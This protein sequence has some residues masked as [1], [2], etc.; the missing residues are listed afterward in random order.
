M[1]NKV[2]HSIQFA[3]PL[4]ILAQFVTQVQ[5]KERSATACVIVIKGIEQNLLSF[6]SS[7][8]LGIISAGRPETPLK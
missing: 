7:K 2:N 6:K 3:K 4:P 5:Y 1:S 8:D